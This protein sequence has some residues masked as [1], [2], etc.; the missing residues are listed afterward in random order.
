MQFLPHSLLM[1]LSVALSTAHPK[2]ISQ[3]QPNPIASQYPTDVTGTLNGTLA[4]LPIPM[5]LARSIIPLKYQILTSAYRSLLPDFPKDM[6]PALLQVVHDHDVRYGEY[7]LDDFSRASVEF[8]FVDLLNDGSTSFRWAPAMF[9]TSTN[10]IGIVGARDYGTEVYP[11]VFEPSCDAYASAPAP[12]PKGITYYKTQAEENFVDAVFA[13]VKE[14]GSMA[15]QMSFFRT[16]VNLPSFANGSMCNHQTRIFNT[17]LSTGRN[18]AKEVSGTVKVQLPM[19]GKE[20][21]WVD[22]TGVQ[23]DT[24]FI[25]KHLVDCE[26]FRGFQY[27]DERPAATQ[28]GSSSWETFATDCNSSQSTILTLSTIF[29]NYLITAAKQISI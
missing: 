22:A 5:A 8:P 25:E 11:A 13:T 21:G 3:S 9:M 26:D 2:C 15:L 20:M 7:R 17:S 19:F 18:E 28:T 14:S 16:A 23:V 10:E 29:A 12:A 24:A 4:L 1:L 6:Y 27:E